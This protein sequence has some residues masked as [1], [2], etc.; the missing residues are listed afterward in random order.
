MTVS[1]VDP[2]VASIPE[3]RRTV[4]PTGEVVHAIKRDLPAQSVLNRRVETMCGRSVAP[5]SPDQQSRICETCYTEMIHAS[6][7]EG[8]E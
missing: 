7:G 6:M 1:E 2:R 3:Q 8:D 4:T 5:A